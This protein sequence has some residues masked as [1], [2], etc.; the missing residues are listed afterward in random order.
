MIGEIGGTAEEEAAAF[1]A[2]ELQEAGGR[3]HRRPDGAARAAAWATPGAIIAGGK[4]T[5]AEKMAALTA[6]GVH[7]VKSPADIGAAVKECAAARKR[8]GSRLL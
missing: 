2:D 8:L 6:A 3:L 1:I 5:A 7:V 4:G